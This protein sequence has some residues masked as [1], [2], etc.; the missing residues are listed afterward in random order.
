MKAITQNSTSFSAKILFNLLAEFGFKDIKDFQNKNGL[1]SD[2][3][4]GLKSYDVLYNL[5]LKVIKVNFESSYWKSE[6]P[7]KQIIWH[8]SA[9]WDNARG[10]FDTW[11]RDGRTHVATAIGINDEGVVYKG[12]DEMYWAS[13]IGC[14]A[15]IF[16]KYG[17]KPILEKNSAGKWVSMNN[18]LLDKGAVCVEICNAGNLSEGKDGVIRSWFKWEVPQDKI[19]ELN[20]KGYEYFEKYTE[21]EVNSLKYW[22]LLNAMRFN[23]PI[24]YNEDDMWQVSKKAL[25]GEAGLFTHNSYR[26][27]KTDVSPQPHL[28]SMAKSLVDYSK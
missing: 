16:V 27:D 15:E 10:M 14:E 24:N 11:I 4:F 23:I 12:F 6:Y 13:S 2:G 28:I 1:K 7:K 25:S 5:I 17:I 21:K 18:K 3:L 22:T 26:I 20:Y 9:G 19:I 8:H